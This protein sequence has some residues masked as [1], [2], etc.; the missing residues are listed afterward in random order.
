VRSE[1][2]RLLVELEITTVFV[3]H[4]QEEA[5][6]LGDEVAVMHSGRIVQQASPGELYAEPT[7]PWVATFVGEANLLSGHAAGRSVET[8]VGAVPLIADAAGPV[9]VMLRPEVLEV[10]DG[11]DGVIELLEFY[12][13]DSMYFVRLDDGLGLRVRVAAEPRFRRGDRV[14]VRYVGGPTQAYGHPLGVTSGAV[15]ATIPLA[16]RA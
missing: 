1:V 5:F 3:T 10:E 15:A 14:S 9:D 7:T 13:H 6:V 8:R 11:D 16:E 12:G 4:D 2:H